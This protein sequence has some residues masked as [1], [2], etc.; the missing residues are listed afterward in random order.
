MQLRQR[1]PTWSSLTIHRPFC[2]Q[3]SWGILA[4]GTLRAA[5][6][7][8]SKEMAGTSWGRA[9][10]CR[11]RTRGFSQLKARA[12]LRACC[13][14]VWG[15]LITGGQ[16][17]NIKWFEIK[18]W[19]RVRGRLTR[20]LRQDGQGT[21]TSTLY[22]CGSKLSRNSLQSRAILRRPAVGILS[23]YILGTWTGGTRE[24]KQWS[25]IQDNWCT[26]GMRHRFI[27]AGKASFYI[28]TWKGKPRPAGIQ[29]FPMNRIRGH[30]FN[31]NASSH[32]S[33]QHRRLDP[34]KGGVLVDRPILLR[35]NILRKPT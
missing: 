13:K 3:R 21:G 2:T 1:G 23:V 32:W 28:L 29:A 17:R 33:L 11:K 22:W 20:A 12:V 18:M 8:S 27:A 34:P 25:A 4:W 10:L 16:A 31:R 19:Q 6:I 7:S 35:L 15:A 5:L 14:H 24:F 9:T 26:L 30:F